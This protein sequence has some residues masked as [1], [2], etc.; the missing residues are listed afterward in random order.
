MTLKEAAE[1][2][3][4]G[5]E[6][7]KNAERDGN[8]C[9]LKDAALSRQEARTALARRS[10]RLHIVIR[11]IRALN[12]TFCKHFWHTAAAD[13]S[14]TTLAGCLPELLRLAW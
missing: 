2:I 10:D 3:R 6:A 4:R 8:R 7:Q 11:S 13:L 9:A 5:I 12:R 14:T 1:E